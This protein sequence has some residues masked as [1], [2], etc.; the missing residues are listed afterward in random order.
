MTGPCL[1]SFCCTKV[2][3]SALLGDRC[4]ATADASVSAAVVTAEAVTGSE[5]A[6]NKD[7]DACVRVRACL[8][9]A[10]DVLLNVHTHK[11]TVSAA[12]VSSKRND[13]QEQQQLQEALDAV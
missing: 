9:T 11:N 7:A 2:C 4:A 13:G 3:H 5:A 6:S 1:C 10:A 12:V 8:T